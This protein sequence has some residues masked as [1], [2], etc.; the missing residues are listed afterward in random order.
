MNDLKE[1][2]SRNDIFR[3]LYADDLQIYVQVPAHEIKQGINNISSYAKKVAT[4]AENNCLVLNTKKT[5]AIVF[6][7]SHTVKLF[8]DLN[9]SGIEV[10]S[11]G[12]SVPFVDEVTSL[13]ILL[14]STLP[15]KPQVQ[16][17][18]KKENRVLYCLKTIKPCTSQALRK[19]L[20]HSL[21]IPHLDYCNVIYSDITY[22]LHMQ[23]Q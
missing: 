23:L 3:L 8:N 22:E 7:S 14:D 4:W 15:W 2:L 18:T 20:V 10:H 12:D 16:Q 5:Q 17:V 6:G 1:H 11:N 21:V 19:R 9:I 13:G